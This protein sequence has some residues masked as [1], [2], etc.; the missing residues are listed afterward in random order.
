MTGL[1]RLVETRLR[2]AGFTPDDP[3]IVALRAWNAAAADRGVI[4]VELRR[5]QFG[6]SRKIR[7]EQAA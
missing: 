6:Q 7:L 5:G 4:R 2:A 1:D 3:A